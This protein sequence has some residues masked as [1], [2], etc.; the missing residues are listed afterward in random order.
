MPGSSNDINREPAKPA[1][2]LRALQERLTQ[3]LDG[4]DQ[5]CHRLEVVA[6]GLPD[7]VDIG[8]CN[9]M[10]KSIYTKVKTAHEF[11]ETV[12]FP[13]LQ[14][15]PDS[16]VKMAS[17]IERL[18]FEHWEDEAYAT[19]VEDALGKFVMAPRN[20]NIE[21]LSWMLRGFFESVRRHVAFE[22]YYVLPMLAG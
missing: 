12:L 4:L 10:A 11:E 14:E 5:L 9:E 1:S 17:V 22:R 3:N 6:D 20:A 18:Q 2:E 8:D 15:Q 19:E 13:L 7:S 16:S 21:G